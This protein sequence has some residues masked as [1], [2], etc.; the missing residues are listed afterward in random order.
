[1]DYATMLRRVFPRADTP[2][3]VLQVELGLLL[4]AVLAVLA[5]LVVRYSGNPLQRL[6][7]ILYVDD[8]RSQTFHRADL[9]LTGRPDLVVRAGAWFRKEM[10]PVEFKSSK[11]P[12]RPYPGDVMQLMGQALLLEERQGAYPR[13]GYVVYRDGDDYQVHRVSLGYRAR[14]MAL[15]LVEAIRSQGHPASVPVDARCTGCRHAGTCPMLKL[16]P[17]VR[18]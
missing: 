17:L 6:G 18:A 13:A 1:M 4:V 8:G 9:D 15:V 2:S 11:P 12:R 7:A 16:Q 5:Y 14:A 10:R 3:E